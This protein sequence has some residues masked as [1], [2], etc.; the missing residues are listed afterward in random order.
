MTGASRNAAEVRAIAQSVHFLN[1]DI[2]LARAIG[3]DGITGFD[4]VDAFGIVPLKCVT[5]SSLPHSGGV[6]D[7]FDETEPLYGICA[8]NSCGN[9]DID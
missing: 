9:G 6:T 2:G 7:T 4:E 8:S 1:V 3:T 5:F